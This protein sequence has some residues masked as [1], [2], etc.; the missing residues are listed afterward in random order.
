[1]LETTRPRAARE[2]VCAGKV[3]PRG[4]AVNTWADEQLV[5]SAPGERTQHER[6]SRDASQ[7]RDRWW[8]RDRQTLRET[9]TVKRA[10]AVHSRHRHE[11]NKV[12]GV[13]WEPN[14]DR[15]DH[16]W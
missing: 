7:V 8:T 11:R 6:Q 2:E 3:D 9:K 5:G 13:R 14:E 4:R 15:A 16:S 10:Q 12:D 1:M